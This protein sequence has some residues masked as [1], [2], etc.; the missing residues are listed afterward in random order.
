MYTITM[1]VRMEDIRNQNT[2]IKTGTLLVKGIG[3]DL[4]G[5]LYKSMKGNRGSI[6][7]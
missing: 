4:Q 5:T 1:G 3:M 6:M 2:I 7:T